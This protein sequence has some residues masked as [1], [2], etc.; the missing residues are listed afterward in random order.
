[1][2]EGFLRQNSSPFTKMCSSARCRPNFSWQIIHSTIQILQNPHVNMWTMIRR[3]Q[4]LVGNSYGAQARLEHTQ[5]LHH[6][7]WCYCTCSSCY[8]MLNITYTNTYKI[9]SLTIECV[10]C[11]G[12]KVGLSRQWSNTRR[13]TLVQS[14]CNPWQ[15]SEL[16]QTTLPTLV[17]CISA[18]KFSAASQRAAP[19]EKASAV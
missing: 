7:T 10:A 4:S 19:H 1:M 9:V 11:V 15:P 13:N 16:H 3:P 8:I 12:A 18:S 6:V 17:L 5:S 14:Y 2:S